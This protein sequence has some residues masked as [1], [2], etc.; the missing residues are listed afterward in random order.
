MSIEPLAVLVGRWDI[1]GRSADADHDNISGYV[2]VEPILGGN[3]L[4]LTGTMRVDEA[5]V[6][7]LELVWADPT[8]GFAA[9]VYSGPGSPLLPK[10]LK[11]RGSAS[12]GTWKRNSSVSGS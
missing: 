10:G 4:Q 5:T 2:E 6:D 11:R 8:G 12:P 7:S 1:V 9:H 3:I